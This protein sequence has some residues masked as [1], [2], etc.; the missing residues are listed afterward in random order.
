[1]S[2]LNLMVTS[3]V[4]VIVGLF[5]PDIL[6]H[7]PFDICACQF[8]HSCVPCHIHYECACRGAPGVSHPSSQTWFGKH[9][10]S[11]LTTLPY[12]LSAFSSYAVAASA[13]RH[14]EQRWHIALPILLGGVFFSLLP[15]AYDGGGGV[16]AFIMVN[17]AVCGAFSVHST[18]AGGGGTGA[19][20]R[21]LG[22]CQLVSSSPALLVCSVDV[23]HIV[24]C[25]CSDKWGQC[26][27]GDGA[28][29]VSLSLIHF[30]DFTW[31]SYAQLS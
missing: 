7:V 22:I 3:S 19:L 28:S 29:L 23:A 27:Q 25:V 17:L 9:G 30:H 21:T 18:W 20:Y 24:T 16:A 12:T 13:K 14:G 15:L 10:A 31:C 5:T 11:L 4:H 6:S 1:M 2:H 8:C 26:S